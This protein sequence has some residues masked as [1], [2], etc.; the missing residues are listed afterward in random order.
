MFT[1]A[2]CDDEKFTCSELEESILNFSR[3]SNIPIDIEIFYTGEELCGFL[4]ENPIDLLFL[5]IELEGMNG[6]E[7]GKFLRQ[8]LKNDLTQI[9]YIS[10]KESYA[11]ELFKIRPMDFLIKPFQTEEV[12]GRIQ[13]ALRLFGKNTL[14]FHYQIGKERCKVPI[15]EIYYVK[16][17]GRK[18][19][20]VTKE[21]TYVFYG[22]LEEVY[23]KLP[24]DD[25]LFIHKS[26]VVGHEYIKHYKYDVVE[27]VNGEVLTISQ[28]RRKEVRSHLLMRQRGEMGLE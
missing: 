11:M 15:R 24:K 3:R 25:F 2:I 14:F 7:V 21:T 4:R 17:E 20:I 12:E 13:E 10:S 23:E 5:D 27:M 18:I 19:H 28:I 22:K 26:Y 9:V 8:E 6:V 1:V 16:S